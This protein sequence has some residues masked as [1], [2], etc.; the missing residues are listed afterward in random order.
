[1]REN[2]LDAR[3][4]IGTAMAP[5]LF[6]LSSVNA[7]AAADLGAATPAQTS[8]G[9][10]AEMKTDIGSIEVVV[11]TARKRQENIQ[12]IPETVQAFSA[13]ELANAHFD[14]V[15][16]LGNMVSNLNITTR[17]DKTPDVVL[18]GVG[19]F[20]ITQGVGFYVND[21]QLFDGETVRPEDLERV[22]VLKGPQGSLYGGS[23]IGGAIKYITKRPTDDYE[24]QVSAEYGSYD[25]RTFSGFVSGPLGSDKLKGRLSLFDSET[26]GYIYDTTLMRHVDNGIE[27]GGRTTFEYD[28]GATTATLYLAGDVYLTGGANLYYRP[29]SPTDYSLDVADGTKP[30]YKRG[31]YSET[32]NL[33]HQFDDGLVLTSITSY[34]HS[35]ENVVTDVDKGP[36]PFLTGY[37]HFKRNVWSEELR[38]ANSGDGPL[39]WLIGLYGQGNDPELFTRSHAFIG[40]PPSP[41][42]LANPADYADTLT[43]ARQVH[44]EYAVFGNGQ[45]RWN[46]WSFDLGLR[47]DF[48]DS[49]M[50]DPL[51]G[52]E[53][54]Q[55][56]TEILPKFSAS[57]H[58]T[59]DVM[60]YATVSR[61]FE[62]G[63]LTEGFD[64]NNNPVISVY[65]PETIWNYEAGLKSTL[66]DNV[67]FNATVFYA[68]YANRLDQF[69]QFQGNNFVQVTTNVGGSH[70]YGAEFEVSTY[71]TDDLFVGGNFGVT[72]AI[73]N[74]AN[75]Y[76]L[77]LNQPTN[78]SGLTAPDTPAYQ[79]ALT[80]DWSHEIFDG[81]VFGARLDAAFFGPHY[82]DETDHF[83]QPAYQLVN[84]GLR[85]ETG[86]WMLSG[87]VS[88]LFDTRYLT[89]YRSAAEIMAP[90]NVGGIGAPRQWNVALSYKF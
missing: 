59:E 83:R 65:K 23:N 60:A 58:L 24:G 36:K 31:L 68:D 72:E 77:D 44:R 7:G 57:Y 56:G 1:M 86:G 18:R 6:L 84:L 43:D 63:D 19:A 48:N 9:Q 46:D 71:L 27:R 2:N 64:V 88:N 67:R 8:S 10:K 33:E 47:A 34:M 45:Y 55:N 70:N 49:S 39:T 81:V 73:W 5:I 80:A 15:D 89:A 79:G 20:G 35:N 41:A 17:F 78:L 85:L 87:H 22:E 74:S 42:N 53:E 14:E 32:F 50:T 66:F 30:S 90:F 69:A 51:Y 4:K 28:S 29:V 11:V 26:G 62:P 12:T 13:H 76:D 3:L 61:G 75:F 40:D 16:D 37:Q 38:L 54:K 82:W 52:L 21:V 25:T